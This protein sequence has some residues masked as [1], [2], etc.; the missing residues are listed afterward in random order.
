MSS[1]FKIQDRATAICPTLERRAEIAH[2]QLFGP[3]NLGGPPNF[4]GKA[5]WWR[6]GQPDAMRQNREEQPKPAR[7]ELFC[8][9]CK[10]S[11]HV[12]K[13]CWQNPSKGK[14][15][16]EQ[17]KVC[18]FFFCASTPLCRHVCHRRAS[19]RGSQRLTPSRN[20]RAN[21]TSSS[22]SGAGRR[23]TKPRRAPTPA[24]ARTPP[25]GGSESAAIAGNPAR[26]SSHE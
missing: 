4:G 13:T 23:G 10:R 21:I 2:D 11:G 18:A 25:L 7:A 16:G 12:A 15:K 3:P 14:G 5:K 20:L 24:L 1:Q 6:G 26:K 19:G 22:A 17:G 8:S 9:I